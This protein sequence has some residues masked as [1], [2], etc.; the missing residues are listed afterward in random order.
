MTAMMAALARNGPLAIP[1]GRAVAGPGDRGSG[2]RRRG[3]TAPGARGN[4]C[5]SFSL[6]PGLRSTVRTLAR[7]TGFWGAKRGANSDRCWATLGHVQPL[8][9]QVN[10]TS[11]HTW[12]CRATV[13]E[14]LL[15]S[16]SRVRIALGAPSLERTTS[17]E[18]TALWGLSA[19][20]QRVSA[21]LACRPAVK[22]YQM[23]GFSRL[24]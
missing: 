8:L 16:R 2:G 12:Q 10:G 17:C 19:M 5:A 4:P 1:V 22:H 7:L 3:L 9:V 11:G 6:D 13:G 20:R 15:S 24:R 21:E 23:H 14:C 18:C